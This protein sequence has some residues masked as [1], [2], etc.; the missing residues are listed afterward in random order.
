[1]LSEQSAARALSAELGKRGSMI[2]GSAEGWLVS[3]GANKNTAARAITSGSKQGLFDLEGE[4]VMAKKNPSCAC[5]AKR[6]EAVAMIPTH[7]VGV[8]R[9]NP[10]CRIGHSATT[11]K[12]HSPRPRAASK[13]PARTV[14]DKTAANELELYIENESSIY[15][16]KKSIIENI[17]RKM[18]SGRYD[19]KL[20]PKLWLYWVDAGAKKY[21]KEF[22]S[23]NVDTIFNKA[24]REHVAHGLARDYEQR[25]RSGE[26]GPVSGATRNPATKE[27]VM[28]K[29]AKKAKAKKST[30]KPRS[31]AQK[32][33]TKRMLAARAGKS[34]PRKASKAKRKSGSAPKR[35]ATRKAVRRAAPRKRKVARKVVRRV[36]PRKRKTARKTTRRTA[37]RRKAARR[38]HVGSRAVSVGVR[39]GQSVMVHAASRRNPISG[40]KD[41]AISALSIGL[42]FGLAEL[43]DRYVATMSYTDKN[44]STV[45]TSVGPSALAARHLQP[46]WKRVG[47]TTGLTVL[48]GLGARLGRK[49]AFASNMLTA[50]AIGSGIKVL[51]QVVRIALPS[52]ISIKAG[53]ETTD[54]SWKNQLFPENSDGYMKTFTDGETQK[55]NVG[56]VAGTTQRPWQRALGAGVGSADFG[57]AASAAGSCGCPKA[58]SRAHVESAPV[59]GSVVSI[60]DAPAR[61]GFTPLS[62][63]IA[64]G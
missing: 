29:K 7:P 44:G 31:A 57:P 1:M 10:V 49:H 14:A 35:K 28:A 54:T 30:R 45:K 16:Q 39:P 27:T 32:A 33:A 59:P 24:T 40:V 55:N 23:G 22:G 43:T 38:R 47:A 2:R 51:S 4:S 41:I 3:R 37:P 36:A 60:S 25:I 13:N 62:S 11:K 34:K 50:M 56:F 5:K 20:A 17:K 53:E 63:V 46:N 61:R 42:G 8:A 26:Y 21:V 18:K 9:H 58:P 48:L 64:K 12:A 52:L 15:N 6:H 19:P